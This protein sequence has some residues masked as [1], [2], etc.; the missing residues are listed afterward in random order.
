[1]K[2]VM[3]ILLSLL[4]VA[5]LFPIAAVSANAEE[6][7]PQTEIEYTEV[8]TVEDLYM[9]NYALNGNYKLMNDIDLTTDTAKGGDWDY[10]GNGWDPIG[11]GGAY[12][13][14]A[15]TGIFD[16]NGYEIKGMC[17]DISK[18]PSGAS[19]DA[20]YVGL[21]ANNAG[22]I[23]NLTVSGD[24]KSKVYVYEV[25]GIAGRNSG[26]IERCANKCNIDISYSSPSYVNSKN[27]TSGIAGWSDES[28][29]LKECYNN[30][31]ISVNQTNSSYYN[32]YKSYWYNIFASGITD[33][34][35]EVTDCY[36]TG[37]L[38]V[39]N[40]NTYSSTLTKSAGINAYDTTLKVR[41]CYNIGKA[42]KAI[43]YDTVTDCYFLAGSGED[44]TGATEEVSGLLK[45]QTL[46]V[47]YD[48]DK[49]WIIDSTAD[50]PYPQ[51]KN[52]KQILSSVDSCAY[53]PFEQN[54][55][56]LIRNIEDLLYVNHHL[57]GCF[58]MENDIDLS[59]YLTVNQ[60]DKAG[61]GWHP[62]GS[63]G[64]YKGGAF[65]GIFDGNGYEI[66][67]MRID[68]SKMPSG[69]S[70][71]AAYVGLFAN[72]A[73]VIKN[74]TVSGDIKSKVQVYEVGGIAGRNRGTIERCA[75]KCNIDINYSSPSYVNSKNFTSGIAGWSDESGKVKE[76]YNNGNISINQ[77]NSSYY[78]SYKSYWYNIFASG[79]TDGSGEVTD[80][81]NTGNLTV[82]NKNTYSSTLT[83]SA[84]INAYDTTL[85]VRNCYNIGKAIKAIAYY[86]VTDCYFLAGSGEDITGAKSLSAAQMKLKGVFGT[87]DF[88][89]VWFIDRNLEYQ[90]PQFIHNRQIPK[91]E[92]P[93]AIEIT[94]KPEKLSY[95]TDEEFDSKGL[96]VSVVYENGEKEE[97]AR[98]T[99]SGFDNTAGTKTITVTYG[100]FTASFEVEVKE[101]PLK[102]TSVVILSKPDKLEYYVG[103]EFD[104][105][106]LKA[107]A[108]Y[109]NGTNKEITDY[110]L[111]GFESTIGTKTITVEYEGLTAT[112]DVEV[113]EKPVSLVS[114]VIVNKPDKL[115]YYVDEEFDSTGLVVNAV[116]DNETEKEVTDYTLSGF[117]ST[118]GVKTITVNYNDLTTT[119][120]VEVK[121]QPVKLL[122]INVIKQ[123]DKTVYKL[124]EKFDTKGM[125][126]LGVYSNGTVK[127]IEDYSV[128]ELTNDVGEQT[129][130]VSYEGLTATIKVTVEEKKVLIGDVNN[131]GK[132]NGSDAG[133]LN[134]YTSGW[135]GYSDR[136]TNFEAADINGDGKVNGAD[137]GILNRYVSSWTSVNK[138]FD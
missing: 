58:K 132:V 31:N 40:K 91:A 117:E 109:E 125:M 137:S 48:F 62:F 28:G 2:K 135:T 86:T 138:Y 76:C 130:T 12:K 74:L 126:L 82:S 124:G 10:V 63:G 65:T 99:V 17:I 66:K 71:D 123:P 80:C 108:V 7:D 38:T 33:G 4:M 90:Y 113:K 20:A 30:G 42:I 84:G 122:S 1:M 106:G 24:I 34:S 51:L 83:K 14:G 92:T 3:S 27:F 111:S 131:D 72:N 93:V 59:S 115:E 85:K 64:T 18:M 121:E 133:L 50:Y 21:F 60:S 88:D 5:S 95:Y 61:N 96:T 114:I 119:F 57:D 104:S 39:S 35:G 47:N 75:N 97:T 73:G 101:R 98:Y 118:V 116:Y 9:I 134:R 29:K 112:F 77:T 128:S 36:N 70:G 8:R 41:N 49:T 136:L 105:T 127:T 67:G 120:D 13:N 56:I 54:G 43:A 37:N 11:S 94:S 81:Y 89:N 110:T 52:N 44:I 100:D 23:K 25:G 6:T 55:I 15:F 19:G 26:T 102:V 45:I 87:F 22:T 129:V 68:I 103:E 46:F 53:M 69:A 16:G 78:N 79:I 107:F 32:S